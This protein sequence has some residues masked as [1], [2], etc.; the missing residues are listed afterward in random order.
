[1]TLTDGEL[2]LVVPYLKF[3]V[4][5]LV[6]LFANTGTYDEANDLTNALE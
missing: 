5:C 4:W 6:Q 3:A 2:E 1:M